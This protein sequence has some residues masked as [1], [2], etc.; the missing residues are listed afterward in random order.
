[1]GCFALPLE[2]MERDINMMMMKRSTARLNWPELANLQMFL[3]F[4]LNPKVTVLCS[5]YPSV[6]QNCLSSKEFTVTGICYI[7]ALTELSQ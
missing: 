5:L 3:I 2:G 4:F 7:K 6:L 1:M